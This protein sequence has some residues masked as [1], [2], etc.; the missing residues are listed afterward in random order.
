[1]FDYYGGVAT[2]TADDG[3]SVLLKGNYEEPLVQTFTGTVRDG[4]TLYAPGSDINGFGVGLTT[5]SDGVGGGGETESTGHKRRG[6]EA[7]VAVQ[8]R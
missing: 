2:W 5:L 1:M 4:G 8:A 6:A 3:F 7:A